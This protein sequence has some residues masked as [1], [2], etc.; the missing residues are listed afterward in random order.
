M[1][2]R[3]DL[4]SLPLCLKHTRYNETQEPDVLNCSY[5]LGLD[6]FAEFYSRERKLDPESRA[7]TH[8]TIVKWQH[9]EDETIWGLWPKNVDLFCF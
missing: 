1:A 3:E 6:A 4:T 8:L 9:Y 2:L 7:H 5:D